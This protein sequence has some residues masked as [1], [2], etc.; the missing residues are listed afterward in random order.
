MSVTEVQLQQWM[1][2]MQN[3][4]L[5]RWEELPDIELYMDQVITLIERYLFPL[6][7]HIDGDKN[8]GI[9]SAMINNYVKLG[10]MP[11]PYKKRYE[12]VHLAHMIVITVLKQ[13][14]LIPEVKQGIY[15]QT[16]MSGNIE[17]A[18]DL[19]CDELEGAMHLMI[20]RYRANDTQPDTITVDTVEIERLGLHMACI[21]AASKII[22][23]KVIHL[24]MQEYAAQN[25]AI[26]E[27]TPEKDT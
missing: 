12:R 6:V 5:P 22:T 17:S 2:E 10:M 21:S 27:E 19:F 1:D 26:T 18:Y 24:R 4:R 16:I 9:T 13:V 11:K 23:E 3:Y 15:L 7:D 20:R 25:Q 14:I 8:K